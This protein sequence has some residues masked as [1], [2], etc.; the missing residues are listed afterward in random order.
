[1][2]LHVERPKETQA[3]VV[4]TADAAELAKIKKTWKK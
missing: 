4:V 3:N 1:M 2:K